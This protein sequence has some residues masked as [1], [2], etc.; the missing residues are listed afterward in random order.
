LDLAIAQSEVWTQRFDV[1]VQ[2]KNDFTYWLIFGL[3]PN[4]GL[5]ERLIQKVNDPLCPKKYVP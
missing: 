2:T 3:S 1:R 5:K 4:L